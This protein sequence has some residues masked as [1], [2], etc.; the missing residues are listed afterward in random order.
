MQINNIF[1]HE[2]YWYIGYVAKR[3]FKKLV[4]NWKIS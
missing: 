1:L 4:E 3:I 2:F